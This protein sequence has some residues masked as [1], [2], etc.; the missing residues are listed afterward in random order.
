MK[1]KGCIILK[2]KEYKELKDKVEANK[3]DFLE[4]K[5]TYNPNSYCQYITHET[6][7]RFSLKLHN[8]I[9]NILRTMLTK[10]RKEEDGIIN[11]FVE[12]LKSKS[13]RELYKFVQEFKI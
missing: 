3:P 10:L 7:L 1:A 9:D 13:R 5:L 12:D 4:V 2:E 8:Q 11:D 6:N